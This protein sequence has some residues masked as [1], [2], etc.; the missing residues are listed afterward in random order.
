MITFIT[1]IHIIVSVLLVLII[2]LQVSRGATGSSFLGGSS[3]SLFMG[4][5]GDRFLKKLV[6][7]FGIIFVVTSVSLT[8]LIKSRGIKFEKASQLLPVQQQKS[9]NK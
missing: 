5:E 4:P 2:L 7:I 6:V 1:V 9:E 3:D 8:G